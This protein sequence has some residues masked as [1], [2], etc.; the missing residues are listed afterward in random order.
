MNQ[1]RASREAGFTMME[2]VVTILLLSIVGVIMMTFLV[3]AV[4]STARATSNVETEKSIQL[5]LRPVTEDVRSA[6]QIS[7]TYPSSSSCPT[8]SYP[9]GYANCLSFTIARPENGQLSCPKSLVVVGLTSG[10]LR[11]SRTDYGIV[12]GSCVVTKSSNAYPLVTH[13]VNG[14]Q[15]LF[16]YFDRFGNQLNPA[17]T[18]QTTASFVAATTVRVALNVSYTTGGPLISYTSDLAVRNNR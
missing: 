4:T 5:A 11:I 13:V 18:G 16:T 9:T 3:S 8:G 6:S 1:R 17:A 15:P 7:G 12:G 2:L 10:V 14:S